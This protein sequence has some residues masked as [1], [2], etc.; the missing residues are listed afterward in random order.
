MAQVGCYTVHILETTDGYYQSIFNH[1]TS[2][3]FGQERL[4]GQYKLH[5]F[6]TLI[7][8]YVCLYASHLNAHIKPH[9][10]RAFL[11]NFQY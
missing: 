1:P 5:E 7:E 3:D 10:I 9:F 2:I 8:I 6:L 11:S 4:W